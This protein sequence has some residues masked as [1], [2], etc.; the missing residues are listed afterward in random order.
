M[1]WHVGQRLPWCWKIG[2]AYSSERHHVME[3]LQEQQFPENTTFGEQFTIR[4]IIS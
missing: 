2:P 4:I 1:I 3:M